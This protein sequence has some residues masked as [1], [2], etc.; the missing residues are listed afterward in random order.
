MDCVDF[1]GREAF[2]R[3]RWHLAR[4]RSGWIDRV[5]A[6]GQASRSGRAT[7]PRGGLPVWAL[8][9][10][11]RSVG[12][13][14]QG[15]AHM[16]SERR[17]NARELGDR[18]AICLSL[19][20]LWTWTPS[21]LERGRARRRQLTC[22]ATL[23]VIAPGSSR[24]PSSSHAR[25]AGRLTRGFAAGWDDDDGVP[26]FGCCWRPWKAGVIMVFPDVGRDDVPNRLASPH[27]PWL[28]VLVLCSLRL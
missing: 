12:W 18:T 25:P 16:G 10:R 14:E 21:L 2:S 26:G 13:P 23:A 19:A 3:R 1:L 27:G 9:I 22:R 5:V 6:R 4:A 7:A 8:G 24:A 15:R 11:L 17:A 28:G 20:R